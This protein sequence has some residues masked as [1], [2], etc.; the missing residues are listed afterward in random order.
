MENTTLKGVA[1]IEKVFAAIF[2]P[3]DQREIIVN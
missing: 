2:R 3:Y 1:Q